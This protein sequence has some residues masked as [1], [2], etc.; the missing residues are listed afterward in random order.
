MLQDLRF[1]LRTLRR[2]PG[3]TL[4]V[5]LTLGL[6]IGINTTIFTLV[7]GV[8][9]RPL[10]YTEPDR[11]MTVW[12]ANPQLDIGQDAVS[13]GTYRDWTERAGSFASL[14]AYSFETLVLG[15]TD[16]PVQISAAAVSPSVFDVVDVRPTLGRGFREEEATPG[17]NFVVVLSDGLWAQRFGADPGVIGTAIVLDGQPFTVVGVMPPRFEF[18]LTPTL[19]S[20]GHRWRSTLAS[21]TCGRCGSTTLSGASRRACR[22]SRHETRCRPYP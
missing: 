20:C 6:G 15:G 14:G 13:A 22:S 5:M 18:P 11:V 10:P 3:F 1:A 8:F 12:E 21:T 19:S 9:L 16:Q 4:V 7:N 17:N 2:S